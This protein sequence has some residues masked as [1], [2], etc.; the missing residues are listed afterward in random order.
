MKKIPILSK[1][2]FFCTTK[3]CSTGLVIMVLDG[4]ILVNAAKA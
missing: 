1:S 4:D 3:I 2:F